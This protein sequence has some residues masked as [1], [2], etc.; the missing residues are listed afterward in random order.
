[1][2]VSRITLAATVCGMLVAAA[3]TP[4][5]AQSARA[6]ALSIMENARGVCSFADAGRSL[7][8]TCPSDLAPEQRLAFATAIANADAVLSGEARPISF[9]INGQGEFASADPH[10]GIRRSAGSVAPLAPG[11]RR[12]R[13]SI[14]IGT[15]FDSVLAW[16]G[17]PLSSR[18]LGSDANGLLVEKKY[19]GA[20]YL[21][22][23][24]TK[25]GISAYRVIHID[26]H[27]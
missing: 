14:R 22:G 9:R 7:R 15:P 16:H 1:M 20:T 6:S 18:Q 12:Q 23:L 19:P 10:Y 8:V 25:D 27:R 13:H 4:L 11:Q 2:R 26:G 17:K 5:L 24:R 21:F 3:N